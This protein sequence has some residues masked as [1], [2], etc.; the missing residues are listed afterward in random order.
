MQHTEKKILIAMDESEYAFEAVR[1]VS[2]IPSL[3]RSRLVLFSVFN[4]I[5]DSYWDL[6]KEPIFAGKFSQIGTWE[7]QR[8]KSLR[9]HITKAKS[10]LLSAGFSDA[11]VEMKLQRRKEGIARDIFNEACQG[12]ESLVIGRRG[13]GRIRGIVLGGVAYK[14]LQKTTS[15]PLL[16]V[17]RK[18]RPGKVLIALDGSA[19]S[20][21]AVDYAGKV[22]GESGFEIRL[23]N[24]I[25]DV[26]EDRVTEAQKRIRDVFDEAGRRLVNAGIPRDKITSRVIT[27]TRSRAE[28]IVAEAKQNDCGTIAVG[29]RGLSEVGDFFMGSVSYKVVQLARGRA[30]LV[31]G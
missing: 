26:E 8:E 20:M 28:A 29:K 19:G 23:T 3:K 15:I 14:L 5:R 21:R 17:G 24:V 11:S 7:A 9:A 27:G 12:Y 18:T 6:E 2:R 30:V 13:V 16:L 31:V 10:I 25:R 1:Y 22:F 4:P